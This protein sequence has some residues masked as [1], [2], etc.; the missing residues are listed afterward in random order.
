LLVGCQVHGLDPVDP[1]CAATL[2]ALDP[3]PRHGEER[4]IT[5]KVV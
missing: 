2:V 5:D 3:V 4:R 1:G